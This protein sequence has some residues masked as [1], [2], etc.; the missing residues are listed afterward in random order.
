MA[1]EERMMA[2]EFGARPYPPSWAESLLRLTVHVRDQEDVAGDLLEEY[3]ESI[4][5]ALGRRA[6]VWYIRQVGWYVFRHIGLPAALIAATLLVRYL[7]DTLAPVSYVRG[8]IHPRS[9]IM[10]WTLML[11][12]VL[13]AARTVW[14]T[15]RIRSGVLAALASALLGGMASILGTAGMLA[16]W[17]DPAT[18]QA[19]RSSGGLDE[20]LWGV[21]LLLTP[22]GL[23]TGT[24]GA[25]ASWLL[26][27]PFAARRYR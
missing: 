11:I 16:V 19:W 24:I 2:N 21:P 14:R 1:A 13:A 26:L 18:L 23:L 5:P 12:F 3:R 7:L 9:S 10:S 27:R 25:T 20:A 22:I 8:V 15:G 4:V 6:D 17:H